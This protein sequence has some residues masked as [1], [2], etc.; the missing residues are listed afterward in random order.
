M[1]L[2]TG[3][4]LVKK[5]GRAARVKGLSFEREVA[6]RLKHIFPHARRHLEFQ[7]AEANGTDLVNTGR[8]K[9]QCKKYKQY[10][11]INKIEEVM[12]EDA[13]GEIPVV[14][15]AAD[16]KKPMVVLPLDE[17]IRLVEISE[18]GKSK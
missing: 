9:I 6:N 16:G 1:G 11:N 4:Y 2:G 8:Y 15:S 5:S 14:V 10:V 13:L 3:Q 12:I 7:D 18:K 17:F